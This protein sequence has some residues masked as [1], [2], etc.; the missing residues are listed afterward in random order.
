MLGSGSNSSEDQ[1][2]AVL[3]EQ[4]LHEVALTR[5]PWPAKTMSDHALEGVKPLS[6]IMKIRVGQSPAISHN[7]ITDIE[8]LIVLG[9]VP[10]DLIDC[11][12]LEADVPSDLPVDSIHQSVFQ[13]HERSSQKQ[14]LC[15]LSF[16][17]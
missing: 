11:T 12:D 7:D 15:H 2:F 17:I 5:I 4:D 16:N 8:I 3:I 9:L 14:V 1:A 10:V 13:I 6:H